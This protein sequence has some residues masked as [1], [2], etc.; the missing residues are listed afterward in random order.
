MVIGP[1]LEAHYSTSKDQ[2]H[3]TAAGNTDVIVC[4]RFSKTS[5]WGVCVYVRAY[6]CMFTSV[7]VLTFVQLITKSLLIRVY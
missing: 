2:V 3:D 7:V 1:S 4:A 5:V 6:V